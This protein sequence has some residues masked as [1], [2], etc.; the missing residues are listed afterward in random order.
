MSIIKDKN[1]IN[2]FQNSVLAHG[3][4]RE[5]IEEFLKSSKVD[6]KKYHEGEFIFH[7]GD[8]PRK[9]YMLIEGQIKIAKDTFLGRQLVLGEITRPGDIFGEVYLF[10]GHKAYDMYTMAL[11]DS[12]ILEISSSFFR[13]TNQDVM[14]L[15][16]QIQQNLLRIIAGKAYFMHNRLKILGS[17]SLREKIARY[18]FQLPSKN[19]CC[20]LPCSREQL[21]EQ[22]SVARPSLSRELS[23]MQRDGI[24]D[25]QG[26]RISIVDL[27]TFESYL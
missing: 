8:V 27:K 14:P 25:I 2:L 9:L 22:L 16:I 4:D 5:K 1:I 19:G 18:I 10:L 17:G 6:Y 24:L 15:T 20:Q 21:A 26:N 7:E 23:Q 11:E 12:S 3:L 13:D